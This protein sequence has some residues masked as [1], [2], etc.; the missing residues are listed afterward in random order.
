MTGYANV[1]DSSG[2]FRN[3]H[4]IRRQLSK[5]F[6]KTENSATWLHGSH[7]EQFRIVLQFKFTCVQINF[8]IKLDTQAHH[9]MSFFYW[10]IV[11]NVIASKHV[12][13]YFIVPSFSSSIHSFLKD[14]SVITKP[15][16]CLR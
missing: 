4:L 9:P 12:K 11:H 14:L 3:V 13:N 10:V 1:P 16:F 8:R 2:M 7:K 15:G 6:E 5:L